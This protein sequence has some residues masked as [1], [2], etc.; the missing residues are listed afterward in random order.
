MK[1]T[2]CKKEVHSEG[3][4]NHLIYNCKIYGEGDKMNI[5]EL[6]KYCEENNK[7]IIVHAGKFC[8]YKGFTE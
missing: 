8:G 5:K 1:C 7:A 4:N 6:N 3:F 2:H